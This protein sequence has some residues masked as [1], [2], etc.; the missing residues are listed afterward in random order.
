MP[1]ATL[2][3]PRPPARPG[4]PNLADARASVRALVAEINRTAGPVLAKVEGGE[5]R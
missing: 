3:K 2:P 5:R 4:E 1:V